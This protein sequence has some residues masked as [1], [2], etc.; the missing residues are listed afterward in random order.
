MFLG[1]AIV[2]AMLGKLSLG[3]LATVIIPGYSRDSIA[4]QS[5]NV[6]FHDFTRVK[7]RFGCP[8]AIKDNGFIAMKMGYCQGKLVMTPARRVRK[9]EVML[10]CWHKLATPWNR[11]SFNG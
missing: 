6:I 1:Q 9:G 3:P 2:D 8:D 4:L 11:T 10:Q 7:G 5:L